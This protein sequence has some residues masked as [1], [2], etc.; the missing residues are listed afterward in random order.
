MDEKTIAQF[1][2]RVDKTV[3]GE[4][5]IWT[6]VRD[7]AGYGQF[8]TS[9]RRFAA[10]RISWELANGPVPPG[11]W[12][13][14]S[15][16]CHHCDVPACVNPS[17]LFIGTQADNMADMKR[18]GRL[19]V[20]DAKGSLNGRASHVSKISTGRRWPHLR[21]AGARVDALGREAPGPEVVR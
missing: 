10:H 21:E 13:G 12:Y 20:R 19:V 17:H 18:K 4:C 3:P 2:A 5:W 6:A 9:G 11:D 15:C 14:T 8:K 7:R 1:W 16:V